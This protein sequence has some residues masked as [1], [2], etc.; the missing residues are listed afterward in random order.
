MILDALLADLPADWHTDAIHIGANWVLSVVFSADGTRRAG[1][2]SAP[3]GRFSP[4]GN[5]FQGEAATIAKLIRSDEPLHASVGAATLNALLHVND[6]LLTEID[7]A[8]WLSEHGANRSVAIFGR[9]PFIDDEIK[10]AAAQVWVFERDPLE[11]EFGLN[12]VPDVLP[13]AEIIAITS[14]ALVN[15]TLD[16]ILPHISPAA[17]VMMLGPGTPL[18][19]KLFAFGIHLL[20]GVQVININQAI[21]SVQEGVSFRNMRGLRRV[22]LCKEGVC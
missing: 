17:Q 12:A 11:G 3:G 20:S 2:A 6:D 13:Q 14:S 9:F 22:T 4:G 18:S 1:M 7:A 10:P 15:H 19:S 21:E 8:D 5:V 16:A